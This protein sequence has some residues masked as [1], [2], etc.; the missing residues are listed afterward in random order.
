MIN[1]TTVHRPQPGSGLG[2]VVW[3][4]FQTAQQS[5][6]SSLLSRQ[7]SFT[8]Y[9]KV[10]FPSD[11]DIP[12]GGLLADIA[13]LAIGVGGLVCGMTSGAVVVTASYRNNIINLCLDGG[14][15]AAQ[16]SA[17]YFKR[18][19][20]NART[21]SDRSGA[22][23][24]IGIS[25]T[26]AGVF[27]VAKEI[28]NCTFMLSKPVTEIPT[29]E[30]IQSGSGFI[31]AGACFIEPRK[32]G[33][34][35]GFEMSAGVLGMLAA[36]QSSDTPTQLVVSVGKGGIYLGNDLMQ[37]LSGQSNPLSPVLYGARIASEMSLGDSRKRK[38]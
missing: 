10:D 16:L 19:K 20:R 14:K 11:D 33:V 18:K 1:S 24:G 23:E 4:P 31:K 12:G 21:N 36:A 5:A 2:A 3:D 30:I 6:T 25:E 28:S 32:T 26:V 37:N 9:P 8:F 38:R 29:S 27:S 22:E 7:S 15:V 34:K 35:V 13:Q 17:E